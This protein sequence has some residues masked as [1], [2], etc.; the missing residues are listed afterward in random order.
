MA[1]SVATL[2]RVQFFVFP[3][4]ITLHMSTRELLTTDAILWQNVITAVAPVHSP[5][6]FLTHDVGLATTS[7]TL[8]NRHLGYSSALYGSQATSVTSFADLRW[9]GATVTMWIVELSRPNPADYLQIFKGVVVDYEMRQDGVTV[10]CEQRRDW[11]KLVTPQFITRDKYPYASENSVGQ[12]LPIIIGAMRDVPYRS[13]WVNAYSNPV[14]TQAA[15]PLAKN[16]L[17]R[18]AGGRRTGQSVLADV[19]LGGTG[20]KAKII[21]AG[22][23]VKKLCDVN[24]GC[25]SFMRTATGKLA[26]VEPASGDIFNNAT[27]AGFLMPD[28]AQTEMYGILPSEVNPAG[29][30]SFQSPFATLVYGDGARAL[31]DPWNDVSY[32]R[33]AGTVG[34]PLSLLAA[35]PTISPAPGIGGVAYFYIGYRTVGTITG[36]RASVIYLYD[37]GTNTHLDLALPA[38]ATPAIFYISIGAA[39]TPAFQWDFSGTK[40]IADQLTGGELHVFFV[41]FS[42]KTIPNREIVMPSRVVTTRGQ[43]PV[44]RHPFES[45]RNPSYIPYVTQQTLPPTSQLTGEFFANVEGLY[46]SAAATGFADGTFT[47][48]TGALIERPPDA[49]A[50]L[51]CMF[52]GQTYAQIESDAGPLGSF[53]DAR[54]RMKTWRQSDMVCAFAVSEN[55]DVM[56]VLTFLAQ[57]ALSWV[58][59][60]PHDDKWKIIPWRPG[61]VT[62]TYGRDLSREDLLAPPTVRVLPLSHLSTGVRISYGYD[63]ATKTYLHE[64]YLGSSG[65][66]SG[67]TGRN[68]RDESV[69]LFAVVNDKLDFNDNGT[70]RS[71]TIPAGVYAPDNLAQGITTF[72][73][74]PNTAT[75]NK[76]KCAWGSVV[77]LGFNDK[78]D[79]D[80]GGPFS[81]TV[82]PGA[83]ASFE[84]LAAA[85]QTAM[86]TVDV[87]FIC[88]YSRTTRK[89]TVQRVGG[90]FALKFGTG[91]N[92]G[93]SIAATLGF[94]LVDTAQAPILPGIYAVE[95]EKFIIVGSAPFELPFQTGPNGL[96]GTRQTCAEALGF[97]FVRDTNGGLAVRGWGGDSPKN[98]RELDLALAVSKYGLKRDTQVQLLA[99]NDS[100]TAREI[101]N[102]LATLLAEPRVTVTFASERIPDMQRGDIFSF[103]EDMDLVYPFPRVGSDGEW[104]GKTFMAVE[105]LQHAGPSWHT[106]VIAVEVF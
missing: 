9:V 8:A 60:S 45:P 7:F 21:I 62:T 24:A 55:T 80:H 93:R 79:W 18:I 97:D 22:H 29:F 36:A 66:S 94:P 43:R 96:L 54:D 12:P 34:S 27:E 85:V 39:L 47:G 31:L 44:Q 37:T 91:P 30:T 6:S 52:G 35:F 26:L 11:N 74:S 104:A 67:F 40:F 56:T 28:S 46:D 20:A 65:S 83:F 81:A 99:V 100:D 23:K 88:T 4:T 92:L 15:D 70:V 51:L 57:S 59:L 102:R 71:T 42:Q 25:G 48:V 41:G 87:N 16:A 53:V 89:V 95:E 2:V 63:G 106:E 98:L 82:A 105:L 84:D 19:G 72:M 61:S 86:Q 33:I 49:L 68:L 3:S 101:R 76:F 38:S 14:S 77:T 13:P 50:L 64:T 17:P 90:T 69:T 73:N 78:I 10:N 32:A 5:G 103:Q 1:R 58:Y 75:P